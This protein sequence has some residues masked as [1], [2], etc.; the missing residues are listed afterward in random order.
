[1]LAKLFLISKA[2]AVTG[3]TAPSLQNPLGD[4][5][6]IEKLITAILNIVVQIGLPAI[7]LAIVYT[8]FLFVAASGNETKLAEAKKTLLW[9]VIGAGVILGAFVIKTAICGTITNLG[10]ESCS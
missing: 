2:H 3:G 4:T 9:T 10:G 1:M 6:T 8:G 7:A 5:D